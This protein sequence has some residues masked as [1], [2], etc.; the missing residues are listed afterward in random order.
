[1][2]WAFSILVILMASMLKGMTGFGFALL[3][4][5]LLTIF[6]P[7]QILVPAMTLFNL[8]TSI[9][10]LSKIKLKVELKYIVPML[11]AS[12]IGIP[13]G[14]NILQYLPERTME[15]A[16]GISIFCLSMVFLLSGNKEAPEKRRKKP[17]VFAGFLSGFMA[18][19][20]SIGGPP[21]ALAMNRKGYA[22]ERFRKIFALLSVIN[23]LIATA[24]YV[25][26][27]MF[28]PFSL[29][30][31]LFLFPVMLL[32]SKLGDGLSQKINQVQ[33]RKIILYLNMA[34]GLFIVIRT[35]STPVI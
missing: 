31:T 21:I 34:L 26:K 19:S 16:T 17:I 20:M 29:K 25:A 10:I 8:F 7:M 27:G 32:G 11:L 6:F 33:F 9:Y 12:F 4:L 30:F 2:E 18:S 3:A 22:K 23:A 35:L 13:I 1:M 14:V 28:E 24:L 15:L 5:P